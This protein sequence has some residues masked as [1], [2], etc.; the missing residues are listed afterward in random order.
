MNHP[1]Y[2][3]RPIGQEGAVMDARP[4]YGATQG[5]AKI[6][7]QGRMLALS[8]PG[9]WQELLFGISGCKNALESIFGA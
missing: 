6:R 4:D 2:I 3:D 9:G 5:P 8:R 1:E 7:I